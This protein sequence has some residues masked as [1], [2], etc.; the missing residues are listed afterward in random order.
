MW[1]S[2]TWPSSTATATRR[3]PARSACRRC[4]RCST[5]AGGSPTTRLLFL[6]GEEANIALGQARR[7]QG[8]RPLAV[9]LPQA[10]LLDHETRARS[11]V[12][13][14]PIRRTGAVYHVGNGDDMVTASRARRRPGLDLAPADQGVELDARLLPA[15]GFLPVGPLAGGRL[16]G[17]AGR[18]LARPAGHAARSTCSTTWPTG[19]RRSTC[20]ARSTSSRSTTRTSS[21]AT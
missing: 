11:A 5:S 20:P 8:G 3:T 4:R 1:R 12:R 13:R 14:R 15:R 10:G 9:P 2:S 7:R 17:D 16:E 21:T 19:A 6:P 18:P